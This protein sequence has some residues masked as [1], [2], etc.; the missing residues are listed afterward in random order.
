MT[1]RKRLILKLILKNS[2]LL[3]ELAINIIKLYLSHH[4]Y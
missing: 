3:L 4:G 2:P 1:K